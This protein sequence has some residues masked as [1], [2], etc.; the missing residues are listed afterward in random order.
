MGGE[1][2]SQARRDPRRV[3]NTV[4]FRHTILA[5]RPLVSPETRFP[6]SRQSMLMP[7]F[8]A[9]YRAIDREGLI[10]EVFVRSACGASSIQARCLCG[11][12]AQTGARPE[13]STSYLSLYNHI[14]S[15]MA[16]KRSAHHV[17]CLLRVGEA[18]D[19][20]LCCVGR[21]CVRRCEAFFPTQHGLT[22]TMK[23][24]E[25]RERLRCR[26]YGG[27][28]ADGLCREADQAHS[29][30]GWV[31]HSGRQGRSIAQLFQ[32]RPS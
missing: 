14:Q 26:E 11:Y 1:A 13:V 19:S 6:P 20:S 15:R 32:A 7:R 10:G 2:G 8:S 5:A 16:G 9:C 25:L 12:P 18:I 21:W 30:S 17:E 29:R 4:Y 23:L 24:Y 28:A 31:G 27:A 22:S 3:R